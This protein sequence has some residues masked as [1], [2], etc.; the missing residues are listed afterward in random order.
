MELGSFRGCGV[1]ASCI[2]QDLD[3]NCFPNHGAHLK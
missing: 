2:L 1:E 3:L